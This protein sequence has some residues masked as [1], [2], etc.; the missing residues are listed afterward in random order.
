MVML[1]RK[2]TNNNRSYKGL[3]Q[4]AE[5]YVKKAASAEKNDCLNLLNPG[6]TG[7][8]KAQVRRLLTY[9]LNEVSHEKA[10]DWY[11]LLLHAFINPFIGVLVALSII[12]LITDVVIQA[13]VDC[14]YTTVLIISIM[15]MLT[16][17][18]RIIEEYRSNPTAEKLKSMIKTTATVIREGQ[19]R[20]EID[21]KQLV[22][23]D[24]I[25][26]AAGDMTP[27][28]SIL[29]SYCALPQQIKNWFIN[30]FNQ[31]P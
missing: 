26:F 25:H 28:D 24:I 23:G 14:D 1:K 13:S 21:I 7:L 27:A 6:D 8:T 17:L 4:A 3:D 10:P 20:Q 22:R 18:L 5:F 16:V 11:I 30:K 29:L 2:N 19:K 12:S 9:G 15:V 31:W